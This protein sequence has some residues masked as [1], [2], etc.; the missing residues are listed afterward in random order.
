MI[1]KA[2]HSGRDAEERGGEGF[3]ADFALSAA[4]VKQNASLYA[5]ISPEVPFS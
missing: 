3:Y 5:D 1:L 2:S 4:T